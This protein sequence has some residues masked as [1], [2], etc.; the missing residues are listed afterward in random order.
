MA[1]K[2][3]RRSEHIFAAGTH[4]LSIL[5]RM[6]AADPDNKAH[7]VRLLS[8][9]SHQG[10]LCLVFERHGRNL[11][12][13]LQQAPAGGGIP[14]QQVREYGM[15]ALVALRFLCKYDIVHNDIKLDNFLLTEKH[16][17]WSAKV[18]KV[19]VTLC[20][21]GNASRP[22]SSVKTPYIMAR[23]YRAPELIL[24]HSHAT[25]VD[26]WGLACCLYELHTRRFLFPG[27]DSNHTLRAMQELI[28]P[29]PPSMLLKSEF[30]AKHFNAAGQFMDQSG[31]GDHMCS[32]TP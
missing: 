11:R 4:E 12:Q 2:C 19:T 29:V 6:M 22:Q 14:L 30:K 25:P 1:I 9:F 8:S 24:G 18:R 16:S 15:Q 5:Q 31:T 26:I 28:G 10:H 13:A 17:R 7:V 3:L 20:D 21:F 32:L 27:A 23:L